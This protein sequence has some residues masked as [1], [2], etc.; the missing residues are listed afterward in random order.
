MGKSK[1]D[2]VTHGAGVPALSVQPVLA[3]RTVHTDRGAGRR[4]V[5]T[6]D[7]WHRTAALRGTH[8]RCGL[9]VQPRGEVTL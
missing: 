7:L 2:Y 4:G 6:G 9:V 3:D 1:I 5:G 8:V